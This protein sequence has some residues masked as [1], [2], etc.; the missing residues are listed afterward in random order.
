M[1]VKHD[2]TLQGSS[3][4]D[5]SGSRQELFSHLSIIS[6]SLPN[7]DSGHFGKERVTTAAHT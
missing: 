3:S 7:I 4:N 6:H 5:S 1:S 2:V